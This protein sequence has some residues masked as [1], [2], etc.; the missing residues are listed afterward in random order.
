MIL[1][2]YSNK[3]HTNAITSTTPDKKSILSL[4]VV[5]RQRRSLS[6]VDSS[7]YYHPLND[8]PPRYMMGELNHFTPGRQRGLSPQVLPSG[9]SRVDTTRMQ[10]PNNRICAVRLGK[11]GSKAAISWK[12]KLLGLG[13]SQRPLAIAD[14]GYQRAAQKVSETVTKSQMQ[15]T[16]RVLVIPP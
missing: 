14:F 8:C 2:V 7:L 5:D 3:K 4:F 11:E 12:T 1:L 13:H 15:R 9:F 16:K 6:L 10:S